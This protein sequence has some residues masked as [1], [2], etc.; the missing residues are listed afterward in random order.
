MFFEYVIDLIHDFRIQACGNIGTGNSEL[1]LTARSNGASWYMSIFSEEQ[2]CLPDI[3]GR[4]ISRYVC[5][6]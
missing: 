1:P 4:Q 6:L 3:R 2:S 5:I